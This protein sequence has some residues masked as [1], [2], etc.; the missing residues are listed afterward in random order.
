[1]GLKSLTVTAYRYAVSFWSDESDL[2]LDNG[3]SC[4]TLQILKTDESYTL[5]RWIFKDIS[6]YLNNLY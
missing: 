2:K 4:T 6:M 1:M 5:K 3:D